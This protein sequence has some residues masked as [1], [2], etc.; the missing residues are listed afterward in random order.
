MDKIAMIGVGDVVVLCCWSTIV[1][2]LALLTQWRRLSYR[3]GYGLLL[4]AFWPVV[5]ALSGSPLLTVMFL[6]AM[7]GWLLL[8]ERSAPTKLRSGL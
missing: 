6:V 1:A 3:A 4:T 5:L 7:S 8:V 2:L